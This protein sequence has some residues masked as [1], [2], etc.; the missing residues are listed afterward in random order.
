MGRKSRERKEKRLVLAHQQMRADLRKHRTF[1]DEMHE[2]RDRFVANIHGIS[3]MPYIPSRNTIDI[4]ID[5]VYQMA[6]KEFDEIYAV[7][8]HPLVS[9][10]FDEKARCMS[11]FQ[12][13]FLEW[14]ESDGVGGVMSCASYIRVLP[15][16]FEIDWDY[17]F[18]S[19]EQ[20]EYTNDGWRDWE[21]ALEITCY[22]KDEVQFED[23]TEEAAWH[24]EDDPNIS[25]QE[26]EYRAKAKASGT[27]YPSGTYIVL[28]DDQYRLLGV[29]N[30]LVP[31]GGFEG[32]SS[33]SRWLDDW[34]FNRLIVSLYAL[35][36]MSCKNIALVDDAEQ[37]ETVQQA[38][39]KEYGVP[40]TK[41]K[42]LAIKS[43][44]KVTN[45]ETVTNIVPLGSVPLHE[46]RGSFATY[47][48]D[49][50]LFGKRVGTFWRP[51]TVVGDKKNGVVVKDY[52]V[53]PEEK[54]KE[55]TQ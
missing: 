28:L 36:L 47:T 9:R 34:D 29:S 3:G 19:Y 7:E 35:A 2:H 42:R 26:F 37:P 22:R 12:S 11:P 8:G 23:A 39:Q 55:A 45:K 31:Y 16:G 50:P 25:D 17:P 43:S 6:S 32:F 4:Q 53:K 30:A 14:N 33:G 51:A 38:Y 44:R 21:H 24:I 46:R 41:Y 1:L 5:D 18:P 20:M 54:S 10:L 52:K 13:V 40:I 49:A 48:E 15:A 27:L